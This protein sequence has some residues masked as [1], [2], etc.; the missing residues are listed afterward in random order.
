MA[1]PGH[2][3]IAEALLC[4]I[5]FNGGSEHAVPTGATYEPLADFFDLS[6]VERTVPRV[7]GGS[8]TQWQNLIQWARQRNI[9]RGF[10]LAPPEDGSERG[11]WTL[12]PEGVIR[13][14]RA[15]REPRDA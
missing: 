15:F 14:S 1:Y 13:A 12:S 3:E 7:D 10:I 4:F 6:P 5:L 2:D 9:N 8:G 11:V